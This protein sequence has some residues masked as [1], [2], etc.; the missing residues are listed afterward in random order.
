M[1]VY[2][3]LG[4]FIPWWVFLGLFYAFIW[5]VA[6]NIPD[7]W[8]YA[9]ID[10]LDERKQDSFNRTLSIEWDW[11]N[12]FM[13]EIIESSIFVRLIIRI[14][15]FRQ[16]KEKDYIGYHNPWLAKTMLQK[17]CNKFYIP[18]PELYNI[19]YKDYKRIKDYH[20]KACKD[21]NISTK[22]PK[23]Y[24]FK[25]AY[26]L[27]IINEDQYDKYFIQWINF[28]NKYEFA[29]ENDRFWRTYIRLYIHG[30][31]SELEKRK[32][33]NAESRAKKEAEDKVKNEQ[34]QAK[35][36][37]RAQRLRHWTELC[38]KTTTAVGKILDIFITPAAKFSCYIGKIFLAIGVIL[39]SVYKFVKQ[40]LCYFKDRAKSK[41]QGWC[42]YIR[43]DDVNK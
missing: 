21:Y 34:S 2:A 32:K 13:D 20:A 22:Y 23:K 38:N 42:P 5:Y 30:H 19:S 36:K 37:L 15:H 41:K 9:K 35:A 29:L 14:G 17:L 24:W 1:F 28:Y 26:H 12:M 39:A 8:L 40:T 7:H 25:I 3:P 27:K 10:K 4:N 43:F 31:F 33:R 16:N 6:K 11:Q 18:D